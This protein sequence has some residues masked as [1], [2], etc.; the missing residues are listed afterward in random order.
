MA[1]LR[2]AV[3]TCLSVCLTT[4]AP[5]LALGCGSPLQTIQPFV[6]SCRTDDEI[7]AKDRAAVDEFAMEFVQNA[8][9]P[10]LQAAYS[11]FTADAKV[12]VSSEKFVAMFKQGIQR[13]GP[14]KDLHVAHTYLAKVT[15]GNQEQRVVCGN[16]SRPDGWVAVDAKPGPAQAHV[17]VD[18]QTLN[19][20][21]AFVI[22]LLPE[23]GNWNVQYVQATATAMV[24]KTAED[25]QT[26]A[27]AEKH[28][29]HNFNAFILYAGAMQLAARGPFLQL[30]IQPEIQKGMENL[31]VPP[32][33]KGP[34]PFHWQLGES[35]F[36]VL[37]V[38]PIGVGQ[39]IYLQID[40]EIEPWADNKEA[41]EKN[42]DL[43]SA[44]AKAYPEYKDSFAGLVVRA[45][46]RGGSRGFGTVLE[47]EPA[48]K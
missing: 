29:N 24:G 46:E 34:T 9:G 31:Q 39:K 32:D 16:V 44:F 22:W 28:K 15:G 42:H 6:S 5:L 11:V 36:K 25:L 10:N 38:G 37:N 14:F 41:D 17:I 30:G 26:M 45:H 18:A 27:E 48:T 1:A 40:H 7:P 19:N 35:S 2:C 43:I 3:E 21:W 47:N 13:M 12:N 8:L 4:I 23:D 33:L 20:T